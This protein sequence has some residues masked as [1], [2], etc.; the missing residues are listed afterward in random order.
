[1]DYMITKTLAVLALTLSLAAT[2]NAQSSSCGKTSAGF[3]TF[4]KA[5]IKEARAKGVS[6]EAAARSAI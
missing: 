1:M 5:V 3:D 2:A 4:K 6:D